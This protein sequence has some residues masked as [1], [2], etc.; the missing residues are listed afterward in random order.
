[1]TPASVLVLATLGLSGVTIVKDANGSAMLGNWLREDGKTRINISPCGDA[2]CATNTWVGDP[3]SAEKLGDVLVMTL[4]QDSPNVLSGN[5]YDRRRRMDYSMHVSV[6][7]SKMR[8]NG[9][10]LLGL[11]C[12]SVEWARAQ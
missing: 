5:A 8:T 11:L 7:P 6:G 1:M 2:L 9:C 4:K 3:D 12:K 10:V